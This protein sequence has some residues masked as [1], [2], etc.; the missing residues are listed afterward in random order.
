MK[1]EL[2][3]EYSSCLN[4]NMTYKVYGHRGKICFVFGPQNGKYYDYENFGMINVLRPDIESGK[5]RLVCVDSIDEETFSNQNGN[6]GHRMYMQEQ[7]YHY[8]VDEVI[9]TVQNRYRNWDKMMTTGCSMGAF[10][11]MNFFLRNPDK[12]DTVIALSGVY[13]ARYFMGGY[14]DKNTYDNSPIDYLAGMEYN[15]PYADMYRRSD[16]IVCVGQG[17]WEEEM[18]RNT[19]SL[20]RLMREKD[21]PC[22]FDY[23]GYDVNHD[24][25]WW[26][27]QIRYFMDKTGY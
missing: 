18:V 4:R 3:T 13:E 14:M 27:K 6:P 17:A 1:T 15:H 19:R 11:A 24:W 7:W 10:H 26:K 21:I 2:Y 20:E 5:L 9:P 23:W 25:P 12:F 8:I 22:W 16:I